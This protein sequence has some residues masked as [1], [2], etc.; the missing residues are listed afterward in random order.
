MKSV[1]KFIGLGAI[2]TV[3]SY[4]TYLFA[5]QFSL[6]MTAYFLGLAASFSVQTVMMAPFVYNEKLTV[7]N[8]GKSLVIYVGYS[9]IFA[10][11]MWIV[12]EIGVAPVFAPLLVIA[13]AAPLQFLAGKKWIHNPVD[14]VRN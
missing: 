9:A 8:A 6:P 11:L 1:A 10:G 2:T 4:S 5:L 3:A 14:D 13:V 7:R 12:L